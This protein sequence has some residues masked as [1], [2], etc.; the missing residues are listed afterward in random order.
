MVRIGMRGLLAAAVAA[1]AATAGAVRADS[2]RVAESARRLSARGGLLGETLGGEVER[3]V[4]HRGARGGAY[5]SVRLKS[6]GT[7]FFSE[8]DS[9]LV[10]FTSSTNE[11]SALDERSPLKAL[12]D[13]DAEVRANLAA[14]GISGTPFY[15]DHTNRLAAVDDVRVTPLLKS[16]WSQGAAGKHVCFNYYTPSNYVCGCS[17]TAIAQVMRHFE[18]PTAPVPAVSRRCAVD[19]MNVWLTT[20]GGTYDWSLMTLVPGNRTYNDASWAA[21]G[22]LTA[23]VAIALGSR[24]AASGTGASA[25]TYAPAFRETFGYRSACSF[26]DDEV[27]ADAV[28][29]GGVA[30]NQTGLHLREVRQRMIGANLDA[31]LPVVLGIFGYQ[32]D[33]VGNSSYSAGHAIVGDGYGYCEIDG[34]A[35]PYVHLN[36]GWSG[37][38]DAWYNLPEVCTAETGALVG[39]GA[40]DFTVLDSCVFNIYT[41]QTGEIVSGRVLDGGGEVV[42]GATVSIEGVGATVSDNHGIYALYVPDVTNYQV[43]AAFDGATGSVVAVVS[44]RSSD[45]FCGNSW[46]NEIVLGVEEELRTAPTNFYVSA[47]GGSDEP[48]R[49]TESEPF[50]TIRYALASQRFLLPGDAF[51]VGPGRYRGPVVAPSKSVSI[52]SSEGPER[53]FIDG[54][55][56]DVCYD[57]SASDG[58]LAGFTLEY[59][60]RGGVYGGCVSNCVIRFCSNFDDGYADGYGAVSSA[61]LCDC[62]IYGNE[63]DYTGG[64]DDC[65]LVNCTVYDNWAAVESRPNNY[66]AAGVDR[67]CTLTNCIVWRNTAT[68]DDLPSNY[69]VYT[70]RYPN[71]TFTCSCT[72][73]EGF[74]DLGG[75]ITNDPRFVSLDVDDW[76]LRTL[77]PC[78]GTGV[79]GRNM[80]AWQGEGVSGHLISVVVSGVGTVEPWAQF[81]EDGGSAAF[82]AQSDHPFVGFATNGVMVGSSAE[83][84]WPSV[85]E[86]GEIIAYFGTTN[87]WLDAVAGDD[88]NDGLSADTPLASLEEMTMR[89]GRGDRVFVKP[90]TYA[91]CEWA[92]FGVEVES[93]DGAAKTVVDGCNRGLCV[94]ARGMVYRGFTFVNGWLG[95]GGGAGVYDGTAVDCVISNCFAGGSGGASYGAVL[96]NCLVTGCQAQYPY[97][98]GPYL[99]ALTNCTLFG[100]AARESSDAFNVLD[101]ADGGYFVDAER[102]DFRLRPGSAAIDAGVNAASLPECDLA[103]TNRIHGARVDLGCYEYHP[104][105]NPD[106][107]TPEIAVGESDESVSNKVV[108]AM[109]ASGFGEDA[110][111]AVGRLADYEYVSDWA[112]ENGIDHAAHVAS[113][114]PLAAPALGLSGLVGE[115]ELAVDAM[116]SLG[117][118]GRYRLQL[119]LP[120]YDAA[121]VY[122]PLLAS[123]VGLAGGDALDGD[124]DGEGLRFAV[125]PTASALELTVAAPSTATNCFF[126]PFLR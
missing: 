28:R 43:R 35:V 62:V 55:S 68:Y 98:A 72:S 94:Y 113:G 84:V 15:S 99:G 61:R 27:Y 51:V 92:V 105:E 126:R 37:A 30:Q 26:I 112:V 71:P 52:V 16:K 121:K 102:G 45:G 89:A 49:G 10:A 11:F 24:F 56:L 1:F 77:S 4:R 34:E 96:V 79:D 82:T 74:T 107:A 104:L 33:R 100:N 97:Y 76:R 65:V 39:S 122:R 3:P 106:F 22:K 29:H 119:A 109:L 101:T 59:G 85:H 117:S 58:L 21:I 80:G 9:R 108:S 120:G 93:T 69:P 83:Y 36:L 64:A 19:G 14:A 17:A 66:G 124:W 41:N 2:A 111:A 90:G 42:P 6:R 57:G 46:G 63:G 20:Q 44:R 125:E 7:M 47:E 81:V 75:S 110:S 23:D 114:A 38:D 78:L 123:A 25:D 18:F 50:A 54:E 87:Y 70:R 60:G 5:Y 73:P 32:A 67:G 91:G 88:A 8:T 115:G 31:G 116:T 13:R 95:Y 12:L 48:G 118:P 40:Y 86:D 103:G 53:T